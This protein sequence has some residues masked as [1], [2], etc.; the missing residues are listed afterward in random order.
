M[1]TDTVSGGFGQRMGA[2]VGYVFRACL[3]TKRILALVLPVGAV[4]LAAMLTRAVDSTP[5]LSDFEEVAEVVIFGLAL[6]LGSIIIGDSV[7]GAEVRSGV[8]SFTWLTPTRLSEIAFARW[9]GGWIVSLCSL[10]VACL[11]C[12]V[13]AG[14][15]AA[16]VPLAI[17]AAAMTAA[18]VAMFVAIGALTRRAAVWSLTVVLLVERLLGEALTGVAQLSPTH[19]GFAAFAGLIDGGNPR[20]GIPAGWAAVGRLGLLTVV[21]LALASWGLRRLRLTGS[22]D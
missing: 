12:A 6:P 7:L 4:L 9:F 3:P 8:L 22:G 15:G 5:S 10:V 13:L 1:T 11:V 19:E 2:L 14:V 20:D 21:F 17:A 18:H 16:A